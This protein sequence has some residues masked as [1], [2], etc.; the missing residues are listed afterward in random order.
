FQQERRR[1]E[2]AKVITRHVI[3]VARHRF[4]LRLEAATKVIDE[5]FA[6]KIRRWKTKRDAEATDVLKRFLIQVKSSDVRTRVKLLAYRIAVAHQTHGVHKCWTRSRVSQEVYHSGSRLLRCRG[7]RGPIQSNPLP[8]V[9]EVWRARNEVS[10]SLENGSNFHAEGPGSGAASAGG[11]LRWGAV[12]HAPSSPAN[13]PGGAGHGPSKGRNTRQAKEE[14]ARG[15][16]TTIRSHILS[17]PLMNPP[18]DLKTKMCGEYVKQMALRHARAVGDFDEKVKHI[19]EMQT[20]TTKFGEKG[21]LLAVSLAAQARRR[22]MNAKGLEIAGMPV[23]PRWRSGPIPGEVAALVDAGTEYIVGLRWLW[24]PSTPSR[25]EDG[26]LVADSMP[27]PE[28]LASRVANQF[29]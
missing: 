23:R 6:K 4:K 28:C 18:A 14:Q 25:L 27:T 11:T 5:Q 22:V 8:Q 3:A 7:S 1:S 10:L 13:S 16:K 21:S 29:R 15:E 19:A 9:D 26:T 24:E 12:R 20:K 17:D 2:A